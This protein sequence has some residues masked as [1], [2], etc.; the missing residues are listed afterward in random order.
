[1]TTYRCRIWGDDYEI[2]GNFAQA[3]SPVWGPSGG[4]QVADFRHSA[5]AAMRALLEETAVASGDD[6]EDDDDV[7]AEIESALD[8]MVEVEQT[9]A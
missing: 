8:R 6:P 5:V 9:I 3:S 4:R 7:A 2:S 1:M